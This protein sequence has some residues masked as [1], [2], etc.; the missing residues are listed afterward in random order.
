MS[1]KNV[2]EWCELLGE[3]AVELSKNPASLKQA[4]GIDRQAQRVIGVRTLQLKYN[5]LRSKCPEDK[6]YK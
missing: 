5:E 1:M 6:F 4:R 3:T 2:S